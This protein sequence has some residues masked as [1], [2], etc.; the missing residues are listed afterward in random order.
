MVSQTSNRVHLYQCTP[1]SSDGELSHVRTFGPGVSTMVLSERCARC[2]HLRC[3]VIV[4]RLGEVTASP[5]RCHDCGAALVPVTL[6]AASNTLDA[7]A[8]ALIPSPCTC[9]N[10]GPVS[11]VATALAPRRVLWLCD[12]CGL[13]RWPNVT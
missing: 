7:R 9:A 12:T 4:A 1:I 5:Y 13:G 11:R 8:A 3:H 10:R 2:D 6:E